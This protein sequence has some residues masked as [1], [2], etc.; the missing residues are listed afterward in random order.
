MPSP[1][2]NGVESAVAMFP[3]PLQLPTIMPARVP[4]V[5]IEIRDVANR[6]LVT[7]IEVLSPTNKRGEG[8]REY[9]DRRR[10]LCSMAHLME[11]DLLR[12]GRRVPM[13]KPLPPA[14]YFVF[15]SRAARRPMTEIWPIQLD[16]RLPIIPVPLL[17]GDPDVALDLQLALNTVYDALNYD[18][19]V[20][21]TRAPE[22]P[23]EGDAAVW[24]DERLRAAGVLKV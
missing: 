10:V 18:L 17:A 4:H 16:M 13:Q 11:I 19:S 8:Y 12:T 9:L 24:A 3:S 6:E 20:D 15:L 7:A 2:G 21:Y 14:P 1:Y 22:V 5:T 23:L